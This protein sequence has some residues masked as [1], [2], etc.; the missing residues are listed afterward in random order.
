MTHF[1]SGGP[2]T[3]PPDQ[4]GVIERLKV[5]TLGVNVPKPLNW[6]DPSVLKLEYET[7]LLECPENHAQLELWYIPAKTPKGIV[8]LFHG[9]AACKSSVLDEAAQFH[10]LGY[11]TL[12][13]DF[14]GS[15]G[16]S[17]CTTSVGAWEAYDVSAV[18]RYAEGLCTGPIVLYGKSMGSAAIL[19]AAAKGSLGAHALILECPFDRL[20]STV[21]N[22]FTSM[23]LPAFPAAHLVTLW[24]GLQNRFWAFGL[25]PVDFAGA[26]SVPTLLMAGDGDTRVTQGQTT[27]IFRSLGEKRDSRFVIFPGAGHTSFLEYGPAKWAEEVEAFLRRTE[28]QRQ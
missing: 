13:V 3:P 22:R 8:C 15:G 21:G 20:L 24:G 7:C 11:S 17:G 26:V 25:N 6:K 10:K 4:L 2:R 23:H 5:L 16:S 19:A 9:Y 28:K 18:T 1:S 27:Q 14:F 12:L